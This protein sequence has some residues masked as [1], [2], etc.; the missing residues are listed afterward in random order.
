YQVTAT[1]AAGEGPRSDEVVGVPESPDSPGAPSVKVT[2]GPGRV[3]VKWSKPHS[4]ASP[5]SA[6]VVYRGITAH[7]ESVLTRVPASVRKYRDDSVTD[8]TK[9]FYI[10]TAVND[11]GEGKRSK[12]RAA[13]PADPPSSPPLTAM[14]G[15]GAVHLRWETPMNPGG[16]TI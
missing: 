3:A 5:I 10:V 16:A 6:Y 8:G 2:P 1:N 13:I 15:D 4:G 12:E 9:Y 7:Q 11:S 14:P